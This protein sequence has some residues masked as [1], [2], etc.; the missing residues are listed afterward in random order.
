[1]FFALGSVFAYNA[2]SGGEPWMVYG[3][4]TVWILV[5]L[6]AIAILLGGMYKSVARLRRIGEWTN[7]VAISAD[8]LWMNGPLGETTLQW[9]AII[10]VWR[11]REAWLLFGGRNQFITLPVKNISQVD[12]DLLCAKVKEHGGKVK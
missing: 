3:S 4:L 1:L 8:S 6:Q 11:F 10:A 5:V 7:E 9:R 2:L 12:L